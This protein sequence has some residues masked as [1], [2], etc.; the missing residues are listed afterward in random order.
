MS[1]MVDVVGGQK[2][3]EVVKDWMLFFDGILKPHQRHHQLEI[4]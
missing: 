3:R 2:N 4:I 1:L